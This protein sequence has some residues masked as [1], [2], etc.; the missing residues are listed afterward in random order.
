MRLLEPGHLEEHY[1]ITFF[2]NKRFS[3]FFVN[4]L[5]TFMIFKSCFLRGQINW[6]GFKVFNGCIVEPWIL[7]V[8]LPK[9]WESF[10]FKK[11]CDWIIFCSKFPVQAV[12]LL[13][14]NYEVS[15]GVGNPHSPVGPG[16][17]IFGLSA[18]PLAIHYAL[19][20]WAKRLKSSKCWRR[21]V[22]T[23]HACNVQD[24]WK[25]KSARPTCLVEKL[26]PPPGKHKASLV[27]LL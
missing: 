1:P 16:L 10:V 11:R 7:L 15:R 25:W 4:G 13:Q 26:A 20:G 3:T 22:H 12:A 5:M 19:L 27:S 6:N 24:M 8:R 9:T 23:S 17:Q 18:L 2:K 14:C 21:L